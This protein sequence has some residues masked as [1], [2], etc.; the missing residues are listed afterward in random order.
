MIRR[1]LVEQY[2]KILSDEPIKR[3][4]VL[5]DGKVLSGERSQHLHPLAK[6][7]RILYKIAAMGQK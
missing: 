1:K 3:F 6:R 7:I 5:H 4:A 2:H